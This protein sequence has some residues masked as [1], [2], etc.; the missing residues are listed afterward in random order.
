M[1]R[2][3][4]TLSGASRVCFVFKVCLSSGRRCFECAD[5]CIHT[6]CGEMLY[7]HH[8]VSPKYNELPP[9]GVDVHCVFS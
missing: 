4:L 5:V 7:T 9:S 1:K 3:L 8:L 2:T 6:L